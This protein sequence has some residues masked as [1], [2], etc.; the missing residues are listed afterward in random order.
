MSIFGNQSEH[1]LNRYTQILRFLTFSHT[2]IP[3]QH[4]T[5]IEVKRKKNLQSQ[6]KQEFS[7]NPRTYIMFL[8]I[9]LSLLTIPI[10]VFTIEWIKMMSSMVLSDSVF[11]VRIVHLHHILL[12]RRSLCVYVY[13]YVVTCLGHLLFY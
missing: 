3:Y 9:H 5:S 10:T 6:Q 7:S 12:I 8:F 11:N 4:V 1:L 2:L 13:L